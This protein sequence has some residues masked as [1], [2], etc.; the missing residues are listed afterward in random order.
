[1]LSRASW[2]RLLDLWNESVSNARLGTPLHQ[3]T[4]TLKAQGSVRN[5]ADCPASA[6]GGGVGVG[7]LLC[8]VFPG[9]ITMKTQGQGAGNRNWP[10]GRLRAGPS[11]ACHRFLPTCS[12]LEP[13]RGAPPCFR[14]EGGQCES[15]EKAA[16]GN[17]KT[18]PVER[19]ARAAGS[20]TRAPE[21][22]SSPQDAQSSPPSPWRSRCNA[23]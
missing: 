10:S 15:G 17:V 19:I 12:Q 21:V 20:H 14:A 1:M 22:D 3:R 16:K 18:G 6:G 11:D 5:P 8:S 7:E 13:R 9:E 23:E 4:H 2:H